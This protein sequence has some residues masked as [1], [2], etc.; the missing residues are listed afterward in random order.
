MEKFIF[1]NKVHVKAD[2]KMNNYTAINLW[3]NFCANGS[4]IVFEEGIENT[5]II[6]NVALPKITY[7]EDYAITVTVEGVAIKA[8]NYQGLMRGFTHLLRKIEFVSL[9]DGEET[10]SIE[11]FTENKEYSLKRRM[12]HFCVFPETKIEYIKR[13]IRFAG[14]LH[15]TH[16]CLEF[17]GMFKYDCLKELSW[18]NAYTKEQIKE[19][20]KE[21]RELG[22]E[23]IPFFN[24][25]GHASLSKSFNGK[26]VVL[27]QNPKLQTLFLGGDG[28]EWNIFSDKTKELLCNVRKETLEVFGDGEYFHVGC[29]EA[30][31]ILNKDELKPGMADYVREVT[32]QVEDEGRIPLLWADMYISQKEIKELPAKDDKSIYYAPMKNKEQTDFQLASLSPK[33]ILIDWQYGV[34]E[35]PFRSFITLRDKGFRVMA[36]PHKGE[37]N[38]MAALKTVTEHG[39]YGL[40]CT[41]WGCTMKDYDGAFRSILTVAK[42]FGAPQFDW[43]PY[44]DFRTEIGTLFRKATYEDLDYN[45]IGINNM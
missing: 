5:F 18:P 31:M 29:D 19:I 4:E 43:S 35:V 7:E 27:S 6:G 23:P 16:V 2:V 40:M 17:W 15:F 22:M 37:E 41:T 12:I 45:E 21:I 36:S 32:K 26:H 28:W 11:A 42:E 13:E 20:V 25:L 44:V 14:L 3:K 30:Y 39:G 38:G 34:T 33:S 8:N 24:H 9:E 1:D 10:L